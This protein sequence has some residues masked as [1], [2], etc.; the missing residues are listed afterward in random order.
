MHLSWQVLDLILRSGWGVRALA[1]A[2]RSAGTVY[3]EDPHPGRSA[4]QDRQSS[5]PQDGG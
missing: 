5:V 4:Q 2:G 1:A 3:E